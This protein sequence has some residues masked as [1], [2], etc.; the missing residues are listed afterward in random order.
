MI[1]RNNIKTVYF[2]TKSLSSLVPKNL[3][4]CLKDFLTDEISLQ[5]QIKYQWI[6]TND[7]VDLARLILDALV[8]LKLHGK[9]R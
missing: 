5:P 2:G 4:T 6:Q 3:Q 1:Q 9:N 7:L 8:S